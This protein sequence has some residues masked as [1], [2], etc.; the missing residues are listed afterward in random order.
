[1]ED[2]FEYYVAN[3]ACPTYADFNSDLELLNYDLLRRN[4]FYRLFFP[5]SWFP[6]K[7]VLVFGPD[8]GENELI[9]AKWGA[10]LTLVE[11]NSGAHS[12]IHK[13]FEKF[14][15]S[16]SL[17]QIVQTHLLDF[18]TDD[19]YD[20]IDA[21]GFI[22]TVKPNSSWINKTAACLRKEGYLVI[23]YMERYGS[24]M[25]LLLKAIYNRVKLQGHDIEGIEI[26]KIL[27]L[28]KWNSISHT[29]KIESWFMDVI[30]NPFV[31]MHYFIDACDLLKDTFDGGFRIHSSW[32]NYRDT[33]E[34]YWIK[35]QL[36]KEMNLRVDLKY[37]EQSR[38]SHL[39]GCKF[40]LFEENDEI[41]SNLKTL[42]ELADK[43]IDLWTKEACESAVECIDNIM[44]QIKMMSLYSDGKDV[45]E[46]NEIMNMFKKIF[47]YMGLDEVDELIDFCQKDKIFISTWGVPTHY[48]IFQ[49][50]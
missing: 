37:I 45:G 43:L 19:Q 39:L 34:V 13:Y 14:N 17:K 25:E 48:A 18:N 2:L 23:H 46:V 21:E 6:G 31:R 42:V 10:E 15:M 33:N 30:M 44:V 28:N 22:Y 40:F 5:V 47:Y 3:N 29:R 7:K 41:K 11:P 38:L 16:G 26:A 50:N 35:S 20:L 24:F 12:F 8:T 27:F 1:M 49:R 36:D 4:V 32:P 9:F